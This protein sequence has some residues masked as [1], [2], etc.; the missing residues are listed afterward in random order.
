M[1][2]TAVEQR[3][4]QSS[5]LTSNDAV[6]AVATDHRAIFE[7]I[8]HVLPDTKTLAI[9]TGNSPIERFWRNE[10]VTALEPLANRINVV[11]YGDLSF[12]DILKHAASLP[13]HS[14]IYWSLMLVDAAGVVHEGDTA[15]AR[16]RAVTNAPIFS[17]DDAFFGQDIVGG[18][19]HSVLEGSRRTAS[20]GVRILGGEKAA[21][22]KLEPKRFEAPRFD[23]RE[24]QRWGIR[25]SNLPA[26]ST[27]YFR[28]PTVWEKYRWQVTSVGIAFLVQALLI[29][30]LVYEHRRR[31]LAEIQSRRSMSELTRMNRIATA[32]ELSASI[33]HEIG[34]PV[35]GMVLSASAAL[36]WLSIDKP[37]L[38]KLRA[39]LS[40]IV[41]AGERASD[42]ITGVRAMFK[43]DSEVPKTRINLNNLI[44]TVLGILRV[45]LQTAQVRV[46]TALD[47]NL[48][49]VEGNA[50]Q[51]QQ[52][53][54]NLVANAME[55]MRGVE[56]RVLAIQ[57]SPA[58]DGMVEVC[59]E[60]TGTGLDLADSERI[61]QPLF[62]T[63]ANGM[64]MG[65]S[66]SRSIIEG[67]GGKIA[68]AAG[69]E[70]GTIFRIVLP[71]ADLMAGSANDRRLE[72]A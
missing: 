21:D 14:A 60:D 63:K 17:H 72:R 40:E 8:L 58:K 41:G 49:A 19:M 22:I 68:V 53:I 45:D 46:E 44:N 3:R 26:G 66:I 65:L 62:T 38:E 67:H 48:P 54:L 9:V 15:L 51:I 55:A 35:T 56:R 47:E 71:A 31:T 25:E 6:V 42:I 70:R 24:M 18:P 36:R 52:V 1:V 4:V 20:V 43:K 64:G 50:T 57:S 61:F 29:S 13:P 10:F 37:D 59:V 23:W 5:T 16:L 28:E 11:W 2:F 12:E 33:A 30:W 32:G 39:A 27:I 69:P 34:Q 7:N